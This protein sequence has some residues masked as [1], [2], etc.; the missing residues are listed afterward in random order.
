MCGVEGAVDGWIVC[1]RASV[2]WIWMA[3]AAGRQ[4]SGLAAVSVSLPSFLLSRAGLVWCG[5]SSFIISRCALSSLS[6]SLTKYIPHEYKEVNSC[7][8][9]TLFET[10]VEKVDLRSDHTR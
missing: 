1:G 6:L 5:R 8:F 4:S 3:H 7:S 2:W 9:K 10:E